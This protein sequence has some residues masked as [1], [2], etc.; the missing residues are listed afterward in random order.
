MRV[1]S[2]FN[3]LI[4]DLWYLKIHDSTYL[5]NVVLFLFLTYV[6]WLLPFFSLLII[7]V[8]F[9][10]QLIRIVEGLLSQLEIEHVTR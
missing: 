9:A 2:I 8:L 7:V 4:V 5:F 10:G 6:P 1:K 3:E